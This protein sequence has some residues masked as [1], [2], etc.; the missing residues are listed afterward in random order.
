[1]QKFKRSWSKPKMIF[2]GGLGPTRITKLP[3][4]VLLATIGRRLYPYGAQGMLSYDE[5]ETWDWES[6]LLL[7]GNCGEGTKQHDNGYASSTYL[8]SG[9]IL[10]VWYKNFSDAPYFENTGRIY[11]LEMAKYRFEDVLKVIR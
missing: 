11:T 5:G 6:Q 10:S 3:G 7:A 2:G 9:H 4:S 8:P 1:M